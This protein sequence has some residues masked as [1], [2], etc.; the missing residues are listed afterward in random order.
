[1]VVKTVEAKLG[2][3]LIYK[4]SPVNIDVLVVTIGA[5]KVANIGCG[6]E[7]KSDVSNIPVPSGLVAI[8]TVWLFNPA[9]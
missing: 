4:P 8:W 5:P 6:A 2:S 1:M 7:L 3:F 9:A